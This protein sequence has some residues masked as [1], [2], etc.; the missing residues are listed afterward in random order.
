MTL[1]ATQTIASAF[2]TYQHGDEVTA[3]ATGPVL[4]AWRA[5]GIVADEP[6]EPDGPAPPIETAAVVPPETATGRHLRTG[7]VPQRR[8]APT[9]PPP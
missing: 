5:A 4:E 9:E 2:G 1:R 6:D 7:P 8:L 3:E